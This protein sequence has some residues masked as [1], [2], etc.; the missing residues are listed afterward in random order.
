M[1]VAD[2]VDALDKLASIAAL[3]G[4][5]MG[6]NDRAMRLE[7]EFQLD[8]QR[9]Q[10]CF[11]RPSGRV[12][13]KVVVT[14]FSPCLRVKKG[15]LG[16]LSKELA[17]TLLRRNE[18]LLFARYGIVEEDDA[19]VVV[20]SADH[21]LDTLDPE[22]FEQAIWHVAMAADACEKEMGKGKDEY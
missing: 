5:N 18:N 2:R 19:D 16:G 17:I 22:E 11:A 9:S 12:G 21:L 13:D 14:F 7:G 3:A 4:V 1:I 8:A 20:A 15:F 6:R 10:V